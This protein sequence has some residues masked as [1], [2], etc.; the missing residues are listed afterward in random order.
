MFDQAW[1]RERWTSADIKADKPQGSSVGSGQVLQCPDPFEKARLA[2]REMADLLS[3]DLVDKGLATDQIV[4]TVGYDIDNLKDPDLRKKY[5]GEVKTDRYGR[6]IPKHAHGTVNLKQYTSS[7]RKLMASATE[8]FDRIVDPKLLVRRLYLTAN[9]VIDEALVPEEDNFEQM[10]LFTD[11]SAVEEQRK[12]ENQD[13]ER[14]KRWQKAVLEIK[15]KYGKNA[16]LR[17]MSFEEGATAR[18]RNGQ[19]G[20]HKA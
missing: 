5:S 10:E 9:R 15:K 11:Y 7:T 12:K 14:E 13:D 16:I 1:G 4:L 18:E 3:L 2:A 20:G 6:K 19:I 17:G 8:L